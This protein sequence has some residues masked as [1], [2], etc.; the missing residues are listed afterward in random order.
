MFDR[1]SKVVTKDGAI[2]FWAIRP[3]LEGTRNDNESVQNPK[4]TTNL[5]P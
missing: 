3:F 2:Q 4:I 1:Y 5:S